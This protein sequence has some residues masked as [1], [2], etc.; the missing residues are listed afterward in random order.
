MTTDPTDGRRFCK[1]PGVALAFQATMPACALYPRTVTPRSGR[2]R[3]VSFSRSFRALIVS[4]HRDELEAASFAE[5]SSLWAIWWRAPEAVFWDEP[6][7]TPAEPRHGQHADEGSRDPEAYP[8]ARGSVEASGFAAKRIGLVTGVSS[9]AAWHPIEERHRARCRIRDTAARR[10]NR[11]APD[12]RSTCFPTSSRSA[13][14]RLVEP[15]GR[16]RHLH[17]GSADGHEREDDRSDLRP[18]DHRRRRA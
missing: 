2:V 6:Q 18:P 12:P 7:T 16:R 15:R 5:Y 8:G 14:V 1:R 9:A 4:A 10:R 11:E 17:A 3:G 13:A